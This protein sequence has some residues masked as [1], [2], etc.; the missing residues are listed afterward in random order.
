LDAL[1]RVGK[2]G[3]L[4]LAAYLVLVGHP[5]ERALRLALGAHEVLEDFL[6]LPAPTVPGEREAPVV[7]LVFGESKG[8][9]EL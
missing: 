5:V 4:A 9:A 7:S 2:P 1:A 3:L 8:N 6:A